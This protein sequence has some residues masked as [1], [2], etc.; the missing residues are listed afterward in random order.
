MDDPRSVEPGQP[1]F[2]LRGFHIMGLKGA[3][4]GRR[5]WLQ[6]LLET[7]R[8]HR[9]QLGSLAT[10]FVELILATSTR[11]QQAVEDFATTPQIN[12]GGRGLPWVNNYNKSFALTAGS[13][14]QMIGF[15][16]FF[17]LLSFGLQSQR[18]SFII[19]SRAN[20]FSRKFLSFHLPACFRRPSLYFF[21]SKLNN[22]LLYV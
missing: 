20:P 17:S 18:R 19:F 16:T 21:R 3:G 15:F 12:V 5:T 11:F 10:N 4:G 22:L 13:S 8:K 1:C 9:H 2:A 7:H 14:S 6:I